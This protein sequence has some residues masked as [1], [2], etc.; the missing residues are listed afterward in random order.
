MGHAVLFWVGEYYLSFFS[1]FTKKSGEGKMEN[2]L[3]LQTGPNHAF[4]QLFKIFR[5]LE[6]I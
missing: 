3:E 4:A 6:N 5:G 2:I 1:F